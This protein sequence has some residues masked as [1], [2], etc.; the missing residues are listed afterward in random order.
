MELHNESLSFC[1]D[2]FIV[3]ITSVKW[4]KLD[5]NP[6]LHIFIYFEFLKDFWK[7]QKA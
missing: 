6:I 4:L 5:T 1:D 3:N 2:D 7:K